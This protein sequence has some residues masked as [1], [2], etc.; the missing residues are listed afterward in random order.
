M[1]VL[2]Y[3]VAPV[4]GGMQVAGI[5]PRS[6]LRLTLPLAALGIVVFLPLD[7]VWWRLIGYFG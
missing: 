1:M 2:P 4:A 3:Q 6:A 7:Y 5:S